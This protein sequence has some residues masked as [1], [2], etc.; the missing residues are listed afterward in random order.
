MELSGHSGNILEKRVFAIYEAFRKYY[1]GMDLPRPDPSKAWFGYRPVT[2]DGLPYIG[3]HS[4]YRNL[5]YA[6]GHAML[7][8]SAAAATGVLVND[9][10][11][12]QKP[13]IDISAFQPERFR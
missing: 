1:P 3:R 7:G 11:R 6:G 12:Q 13:A 4:Q 8:V 10:I 9:I 5:V 2:P